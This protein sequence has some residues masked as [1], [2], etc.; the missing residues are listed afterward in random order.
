[1]R[2]PKRIDKVLN[3]IRLVWSE[4]PDLRLTQLIINA[5]L[6]SDKVIITDQSIFGVEDE[7]LMKKMV[8]FGLTFVEDE[9]EDKLLVE[10]GMLDDLIREAENEASRSWQDFL[11]DWGKERD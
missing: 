2:D 5:L 3:I 1:M 10:S 6:R 9:T 4:C 7:V 11:E 8:E